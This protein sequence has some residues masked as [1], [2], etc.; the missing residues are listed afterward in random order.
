MHATAEQEEDVRQ[1]LIWPGMSI[2][3]PEPEDRISN[4]VRT[5]DPRWVP[6]DQ[7]TGAQGALYDERAA[8]VETA[9]F[10]YF[11]SKHGWMPELETE[12]EN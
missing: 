5:A 10:V 11:W 3:E 1:A 12:I 4:L 2:V 6:R 8:L 7:L 9:G